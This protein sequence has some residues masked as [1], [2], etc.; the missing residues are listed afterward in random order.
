MHTT[1]WEVRLETQ[2]RVSGPSPHPLLWENGFSGHDLVKVGTTGV[3]KTM[4]IWLRRSSCTY[5]VT[6]HQYNM[7]KSC[8]SKPCLKKKKKLLLSFILLLF[9]TGICNNPKKTNIPVLKGLES[10]LTC[11]LEWLPGAHCLSR[12]V[13]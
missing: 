8:V 9:Q 11:V 6:V 5:P 7:K 2:V 1:G 3:A 13:C 12:S 4:G 10:L